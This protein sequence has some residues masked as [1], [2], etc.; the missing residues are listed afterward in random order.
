MRPETGSER[1]VNGPSSI[2]ESAL[3]SVEG[4]RL[5]LFNATERGVCVSIRGPEGDQ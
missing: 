2:E 1:Q 3:C 4:A 5:V